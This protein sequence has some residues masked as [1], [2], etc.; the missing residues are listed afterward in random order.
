MRRRVLRVELPNIA[1]TVM[2]SILPR[3]YPSSVAWVEEARTV[4]LS[5]NKVIVV[6]PDEK[7]GIANALP[8]PCYRGATYQTEL[9][10]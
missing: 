9:R 2:S 10:C 8:L 1:H 6:T 7:M 3:T 4:S 5:Q